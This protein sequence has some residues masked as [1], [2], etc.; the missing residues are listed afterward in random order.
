M[1]IIY[2]T[3]GWLFGIWISPKL[4]VPV[5][6][7]LIPLG[8]VVLAA[9]FL[10]LPAIFRTILLILAAICLGSLRAGTAITPIGNDHI[11]SYNGAENI[12]LTGF[13]VEEPEIRDTS[14]SLVVQVQS[15]TG[16]DGQEKPVSGQVQIRTGRYPIIKYGTRVQLAGSLATPSNRKHKLP[17][18]EPH[19]HTRQNINSVMA[20]IGHHNKEIRLLSPPDELAS[21]PSQ[22]N[23]LNHVPI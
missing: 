10:N 8:G 13:V 15:I 4:E 5:F 17:T 16:A 20:S 1:T 6:F 9:L 18:T 7:W 12:Q 22:P 19:N 3:V 21:H 23:R 11:A 14:S 2:W